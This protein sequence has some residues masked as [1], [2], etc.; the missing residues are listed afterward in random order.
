MT[1]RG[2]ITF[3]LLLVIVA[4]VVVV[5]LIKSWDTREDEEPNSQ[6]SGSHYECAGYEFWL[7]PT[8][9]AQ[10]SEERAQYGSYV[11]LYGA[12]GSEP[13]QAF[14]D[15]DLRGQEIYRDTLTFDLGEP[16]DFPGVGSIDRKSV[17]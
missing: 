13:V 4:A 1:R 10:L 8:G 16:Q 5:V 6:Q 14:T 7:S 11:V 17:V 2:K 15:V 12:H 9:Q 3:L